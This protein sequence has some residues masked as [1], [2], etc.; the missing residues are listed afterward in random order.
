MNDEW[1]KALVGGDAETLN[2]ILDSSLR[3]QWKATIKPTFR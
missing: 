3:I 1:V 2:R